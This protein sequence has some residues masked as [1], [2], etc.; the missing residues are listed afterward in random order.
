M[1]KTMLE[2]SQTVNKNLLQSPVSFH[3]SSEDKH[4]DAS[5]GQTQTCAHVIAYTEGKANKL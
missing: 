5:R 4:M 3:D 1:H 2:Y